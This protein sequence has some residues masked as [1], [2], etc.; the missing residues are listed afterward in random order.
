MGS[1]RQD[2]AAAQD[3]SAAADLYPRRRLPQV[4]AQRQKPELPLR[5][6][7]PR[8]RLRRRPVVRAV[9]AARRAGDRRRSVRQQYRGGEAACRQGPSVDRL[10]LHHGR[11][12][13]RA[14]ALRHRAGDG[15]GRACQRCRRVPQSLRGDAEAR[16]VDGDFDA[17]PQLEELC[18]RHRRRGI[19]PALAAARHP[20]MGQVRHPRRTRASSAQQQAGDHRADRRG[21]SARSPTA[22]ASPP[23]WT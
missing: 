1:Q 14:R 6:A 15:S 11:G 18:A 12:D 4:R 16:R 7:H 22:G 20:S 8:Y 10:S 23:T 2:G 17:E 3:Q 13:G 5:P 9:Y 21:L 19:C